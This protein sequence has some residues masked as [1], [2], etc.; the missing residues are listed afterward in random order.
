MPFKKGQVGNPK[1]RPKGTKNKV[2][3]PIVEEIIAV[4]AEL[5]A[6]G[7]GLLSCAKQNPKWFFEQFVKNLIPKNVEVTGEDGGPVQARVEV[8][9][10]KP[11]S[12]DS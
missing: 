1:G 9:F 5:E 4:A 2:R 3:K 6:E 8:I 10:V 12:S 7:K 11:E